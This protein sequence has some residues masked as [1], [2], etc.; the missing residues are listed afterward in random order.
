MNTFIPLTSLT[1]VLQG[2]HLE[3]EIL[4]SYKIL[5]RSPCCAYECLIQCL[6]HMTH[7]H[8][9]WY[10]YYGTEANANGITL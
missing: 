4:I 8:G 7:F 2:H 10:K 1:T 9:T 6:N 3:H 5:M